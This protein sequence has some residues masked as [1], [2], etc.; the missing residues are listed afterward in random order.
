ML[1]IGDKFRHGADEPLGSVDC[2]SQRVLNRAT[3]G[4]VPCVVGLAVG[5]S[6]KR[7]MLAACVN[8]L[9]GASETVGIECPFHCL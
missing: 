2:V 5:W 6:V 8:N 9:D 7:K 3:A 4:L 1:G